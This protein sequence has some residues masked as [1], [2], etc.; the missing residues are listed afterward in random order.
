M[1]S[2]TGT[3]I[4]NVRLHA[5]PASVAVGEASKYRSDITLYYQGK[6]A[7]MKSIIQIM[8]ISV[9]TGGLIEVCCQGEDEEQAAAGIA[10][11]L[12]NKQII[13]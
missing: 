8:K 4:E 11:V 10:S 3:V 2:F 6:S 1:K 13:D 5:R 7:N 9:P 12:R